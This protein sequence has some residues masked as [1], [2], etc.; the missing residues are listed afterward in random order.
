MGITEFFQDNAA[1]ISGLSNI[2]TALGTV[3]AV[4]TALYLS[5]KNSKPKIKVYATVGV[6]TPEMTEHLWISCVNIGMTPVTCNSFSFAPRMSKPLRIMPIHQLEQ[7]STQMP[8]KLDY[9][10][11]ADHHFDERFFHDP[12]LLRVLSKYKW[13]AKIKLKYLWRVIVNTN[14]GVFE[15]NL[16]NDLI[17]KIL[18]SQYPTNKSQ[19]SS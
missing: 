4:V 3:G 13:L 12:I 19:K 14:I 16:S 17:E 10:E 18:S 2:F 7:L 1:V 9:S 8:R 6:I 15:G 11:K 5:N